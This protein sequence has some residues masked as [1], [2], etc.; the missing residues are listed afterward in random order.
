MDDCFFYAGEADVA[1]AFDEGLVCGPT[2][3]PSGK[4]ISPTEAGNEFLKKPSSFMVSKDNEFDE[5][6]DEAPTRRGGG[7]GAA[8]EALFSMLKDLRKKIQSSIRIRMRE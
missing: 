6:E 3:L 2:V 1:K 8:D 5:D 7:S 4:I